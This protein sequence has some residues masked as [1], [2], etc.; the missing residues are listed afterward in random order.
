M[1]ELSTFVVLIPQADLEKIDEVELLEGLRPFFRTL[2]QVALQS[3]TLQVIFC[4]KT[5]TVLLNFFDLK[6]LLW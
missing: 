3:G 5:L 2:K 4:L 1:A 6:G